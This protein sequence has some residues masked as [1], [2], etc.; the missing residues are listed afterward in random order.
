MSNSVIKADNIIKKYG[1]NYALVGV[2]VEIEKGRIYGLL[3]R[4]GAGKSTLMNIITNRV[5]ATSGRCTLDGEDLLEN[6]KAL[7]RIYAMS[8]SVTMPA[9]LTFKQAVN[10]TADFYGGFDKD[11]A[12]SL[13]EKFKL[14][15]KKRLSALSTGYL[16]VS[17]LILTIEECENLVEDVIIIDKGKVLAAG[18]TEDILTDG[19][20]VTGAKS[21]VCAYCQNKEVLCM[22][23]I[24]TISSAYLK[25]TPENVPEGLEISRPDLQQVF[26]NLTGEEGEQ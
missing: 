26:I 15:P 6:D 21:L 18:K 1:R 22:K 13:A 2:S 12:Y 17:K 10:I 24:G 7:N 23:N 3:G 14:D 16:T 19:Y 8:E 9:G 4:N 25:G 5:F 11:Y 20:S